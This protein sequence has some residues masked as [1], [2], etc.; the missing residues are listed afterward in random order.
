MAANQSDAVRELATSRY[1]VKF[2]S[3]RQ[4]RFSIPVAEVK[5]ELEGQGFPRNH[6]PQICEALRSKKF[7]R[8]NNLKL[9][10]TDGPPSLTSSTVVFH[11]ETEDVPSPSAS[12]LPA[13]VPAQPA[14]T[15]RTDAADDA[16]YRMRGFLKDVFE[17][18]GGGETF[19]RDLRTGDR[20]P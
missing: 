15:A 12:A 11:Y 4:T 1:V 20:E 14:P 16:F 13:D 10:G 5:A 7:L 3:R 9:V 6:T 8:T 18:L 2:K 19:L 17:Q